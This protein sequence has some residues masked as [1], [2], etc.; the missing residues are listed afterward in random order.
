MKIDPSSSSGPARTL[1]DR[2]ELLRQGDLINLGAASILG[3]GPSPTLHVAYPTMA[4]MADQPWSIM[5]V[6]ELGWYVVL[7]QDCDIAR[8]PDVEPCILVCPLEAVPQPDWQSLRSGPYSPREFP[9]PEQVHMNLP[10]GT[11]AVAN[12]RFPAS[13]EKTALLSSMYVR[14]APLSAALRLRFREWVAR[15]FGRAP[16]PDSV[17]SHVLQPCGHRIAQLARAARARPS[18]R[19]RSHMLVLLADEWY[20]APGEQLISLQM[21]ITAA[22]AKSIGFWD[23]NHANFSLA[24]IEAARIELQADLNRRITP[25]LGYSLTLEVHTLDRVSAD[26]YRSWSPWT[27]DPSPGWSGATERQSAG[28]VDSVP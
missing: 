2:L 27:W 3:R 6:S 17:S 9:Y 16:H 19:S 28:T 23:D 1:A 21:I 24:A 8:S 7:S 4:P 5:L 13:M 25:G 11:A 22:G 18:G 15:R 26:T 20:V 12:A 14:A 10:D